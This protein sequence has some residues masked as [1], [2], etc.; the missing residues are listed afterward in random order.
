M[1]VDR[2]TEFGQ[3]AAARLEQEKTGWLTTITAGGQPKSIPVWFLWQEDES[4]LI[5]SQPD[6]LKLRNIEVNP[7]VSFNLDSDGNGGNIVRLEGPAELPADY[8]LGSTIPGYVEKYRD[9]IPALN[10]TVE[11]MTATYSRAII[12][13]PERLAGH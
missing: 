8:P 9:L 12:I 4:L 7:R 6:Q 2:T 10:M 3:R 11:E 1:I 5:Y 13:R